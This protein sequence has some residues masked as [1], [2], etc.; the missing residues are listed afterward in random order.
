MPCPCHD[1]VPLL[2][3]VLFSA[4]AQTPQ[5]VS[6]VIMN[7]KRPAN[8]RR[9]VKRYVSMDEV[10]EI[11]LIMCLKE[12]AFVVEHPKVRWHSHSHT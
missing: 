11:I 2:Y 6:V 3:H 4:H 12:T 8:V 10:V 1:T 7:Y 9:I 5:G